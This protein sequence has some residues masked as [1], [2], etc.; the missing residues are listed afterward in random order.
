[1]SSAETMVENL[2]LGDP[3]KNEATGNSGT[4]N[5]ENNI[6]CKNIEKN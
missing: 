4:Q 5:L 1:M 3:S 2:H 6:S